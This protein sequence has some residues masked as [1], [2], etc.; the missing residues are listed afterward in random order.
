MHKP[1]RQQGRYQAATVPQWTLLFRGSFLSGSF[2][3]F[4]FSGSPKAETIEQEDQEGTRQNRDRFAVLTFL[5][6]SFVD[7][8]F[9]HHRTR[10]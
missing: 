7:S 3:F 4:P 5:F 1:A 9:R 6:S 2:L 10:R 8:S